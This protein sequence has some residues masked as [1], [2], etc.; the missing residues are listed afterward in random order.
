MPEEDERIVN[1]LSVSVDNREFPSTED[2][3]QRYSEVYDARNR[4]CGDDFELQ[5]QAMYLEVA[6]SFGIKFYIPRE[7]VVVFF[8]SQLHEKTVKEEIEQ[9]LTSRD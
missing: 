2:L 6:M 5:E 3:I 1:F 4:P 9:Y 8:D 7:D